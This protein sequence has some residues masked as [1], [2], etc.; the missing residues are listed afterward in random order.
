MNL[1]V[2]GASGFIGRNLI[3]SLPKTS[4]VVAIYHHSADF[5]SFIKDHHLTHVTAIKCDLTNDS[6]VKAFWQKYKQFEACVYLSANGDP[7]LSA[8]EPLLDFQKNL[9]ALVTFF[10]YAKLQK[11]IFFSSGA[12]YDGLTGLVSPESKLNPKLPY[13]ISKLAS[14]QYIQFFAKKGQIENYIILRFFGAFGPYEPERKIYTK[15]VRAFALEGKDEFVVRGDGKNLIDAM[16]VDDTIDGIL[17][18]MA[19]SEK[20]KIVDFCSGTPVAIDDLVKAAA[21]VLTK[22]PI[23]I[24][25]QGEVPEYIA[26]RVS[27]QGMKDLFGFKPRISL[28][29]GL[30]SF[31]EFIKS[32]EGF[33][34]DKK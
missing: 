18:V 26:F 21:K 13:A 28:E 5:P 11:L 15:L 17:K 32:K 3:L 1:L 16:Y 22:K 25:H 14:E 27:A 29:D 6:D 19:S 31:L 33:V 12:V 23:K 30:K 10:A 24:I 34:H 7:A 9:L 4:R 20:N 8:H 2:T